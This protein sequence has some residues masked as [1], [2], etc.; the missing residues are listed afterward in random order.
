MRAWH[1]V[2]MVS[3]YRIAPHFRGAKFFANWSF[4]TFRGSAILDG[5]ACFSKHFTELKFCGLRRI[6]KNRENYAPQKFGAIR[7]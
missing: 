1:L 6:R 3:K 4:E 7:Y 5:R 2:C